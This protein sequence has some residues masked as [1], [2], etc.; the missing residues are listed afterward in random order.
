MISARVSQSLIGPSGERSPT[1][2]GRLT[3]IGLGLLLFLLIFIG[4]QSLS[5]TPAFA[6]TVPTW[7]SGQYFA[8]IQNA[9]FCD[10][11]AVSNAASLPLTSMTAGVTPS[12][13]ANYSIQDVNLATGTAQIC[14][15]DTNSPVAS[16]TPP[17][18]KPVATNSGGSA[19]GTI[20]IGSYGPC[21]WTST[22][23]TT[24]EFDSNRDLYQTGSQSVFGAA[25]VNG[26]VLGSTSNY[27]TCTDAMVS[28]SGGDADTFNIN[29]SNPLPTPTDTNPSAVPA[30][31]PASNYYL[32]HGGCYGFVNVLTSYNY[33]NFG[34]TTSLTAPSPWVNGG[35]CSYTQEGTF[36]AGG[37]TDTANATCPP[38]QADVNA[39]Y[40]ACTISVS[41]ENSVNGAAT[42]S[43]NDLFF[44]GQPVPQT[45]TAT[46]STAAAQPGDTVS[47]TAGYNWWGSSG[48]APNSG[49]YGDDQIGDMY[50]VAAPSVFIG[51]NR[52]SAVP[53]LNSTVTV[54]ADSYA[55][56]GA[57]SSSVGP[58]PC[59]MTVGQPTGTFR[60]PSG[61]APGQYNVYIDES[62]TT[63]LPGNGPNDNYQTARGTSLG[64]VEAVAPINVEGVMV[65]KTSTTA[66]QD[67]GY[68]AAG[69]TITYTYAVTNTG[70]DA[71]TGIQVN[72]NKI[73][74]AD[75]SC[76]STTLAG[77]A[78]ENCTGTYTVTQADVDNGSV[79]N[80]ATIT[81]TSI[82]DETL[83]SAPSS[84]TVDATDAVSS[85]SLV[86]S[87]S[88]TY[89]D[90]GYGKAG[91]VI[92][93]SYVVTN[94]GT[95]TESNIG[96]T[97]NLIPSADITCPDALL[98]PG[99]SETCTAS[100]T[101]SQAD[102]DAGSVTN[103]A[104]ATGT[105]PSSTPVDSAT[106]S[107]TIDASDATSS[108]SL[109]TSTSSNGYRA[110]GDEIDYSYSATNTGTTTLSGIG[111]SDNLVATVDC[112]QPSLVPGAYETC[113]GVYTVT[114]GDVDAGSVTDTATASATWDGN[115][116][117]YHS[118]TSS[119][120][121]QVT[122]RAT[123]TYVDIS[124][125][126]TSAYF[127][128]SFTP[129]VSTDGDGATSVTSSTGGICV[130]GPDSSVSY[131]GV[132]TCTLTAHVAQG[133]TYTAADGSPQSFTVLGFTITTASLSDATP[134]TR[135]GPVTLQA[136][137]VGV[138]AP[139]YTTTLKWDK[140]SLPKGMQFSSKGVLSGTPSKTLAAGP[141]SVTVKATETV[142]T[143][144]GTKKV[145]TKT[146][147]LATIPLIIE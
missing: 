118:N 37:N 119:V 78:S 39:G 89:T 111:V 105:N 33:T 26:E 143:L 59:T 11:V 28:T 18:L 65:V 104:Y 120:T 116:Q 69:D 81:A 73:P 132:G 80:A 142:T 50:P 115:G 102:V 44:N 139:G 22:R 88:T 30:D 79:T 90:G 99:A 144:K 36:S 125:V 138:S 112:G 35:T 131:V 25:I 75:I 83:T 91:D 123:P 40:V 71:V 5:P 3:R 23:G 66:Y 21:N 101:V 45:P 14:G 141:R 41:S 107:A 74:S 95:T 7:T 68:G 92:N 57:E 113:T 16:G 130:V 63:P 122:S 97:D 51:T 19:T 146:T 114:P 49:P 60:V 55:C 134:G 4:E 82:A 2:A 13:F 84:V 76:P 124:N 126:P 136:A 133:T 15:T 103:T 20:P 62:N 43:S 32:G 72:D 24:S 54:G 8:A 53:V 48:G 58:N 145:E 38:S 56:T 108:L 106:D 109:V 9:P 70:P 34:S 147:A 87:A 17:A 96:V 93:Y 27:P 110:A 10:D 137:G 12:G 31:L 64:T 98:A 129:A 77:G 1:S 100:Y 127:G 61:L 6:A 29:T 46:L 117:T 94:T 128:G 52:A 86:K 85:L 42:Y 140:V 135:Y 121:V 67:G 47:V